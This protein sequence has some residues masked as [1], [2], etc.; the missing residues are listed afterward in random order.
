M[1]L[2]ASLWPKVERRLS[3]ELGTAIRQLDQ[4]G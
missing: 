1:S 4:L 2:G 3:K